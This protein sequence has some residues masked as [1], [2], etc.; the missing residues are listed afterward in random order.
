MS[1]DD[2]CALAQR[3]LAARAE[4]VSPT[5]PLRGSPHPPRLTRA[6]PLMETCKEARA[7]KHGQGTGAVVHGYVGHDA[8]M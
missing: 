2:V 3:Q 8:E 4:L 6:F 5:G 7:S 1:F